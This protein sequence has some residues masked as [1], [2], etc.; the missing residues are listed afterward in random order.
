MIENELGEVMLGLA[1][2]YESHSK[3][4]EIS[5]FMKQF[6][7]K[8]LNNSNVVKCYVKLIDLNGNDK[9]VAIAVVD[10]DEVEE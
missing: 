9:V 1:L 4:K 6:I 5:I 2:L 3:F 8:Y 7:D 10:G